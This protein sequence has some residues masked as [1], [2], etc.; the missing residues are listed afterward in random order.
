[1]E[2]KEEINFQCNYCN[3]IYKRKYA[4]NNHI[5]KCKFYNNSRAIIINEENNS[6]INSNPNIELNNSTI[7][8][9]L[10]D[11]TNK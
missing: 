5:T 9:I 10:I 8:K 3:K 2:T 4:Y 6:N 7:L 1:M 11:L